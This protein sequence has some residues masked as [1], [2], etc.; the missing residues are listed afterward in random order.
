MSKK[1]PALKHALPFDKSLS[2]KQFLISH[3][4]ILLIG[5]FYLG[6][7]YF[8]L[9]EGKIFC[10]VNS[11]LKDYIPVTTTPSSFSL[12]IN[13]PDDEAAVFEKSIV[14]SGTSSPL[15]TII[16]ASSS[17]TVGLETSNK[18]EF[19]KVFSLN[20]GLNLITITAFDQNGN[21]K[22]DFRTVYYSQEKLP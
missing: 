16:I 14:I 19:S 12:E 7:L 11:S 3:L 6:V 4:G 5:L 20:P 2:F 21:K 1:E 15:A 22:Q 8:F 18:G 13:S 10:C 9:N 17:E